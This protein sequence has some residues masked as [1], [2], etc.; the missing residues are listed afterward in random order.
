MRQLFHTGSTERDSLFTETI[1]PLWLI[2]FLVIIGES[3]GS[4]ALLL[5]LLTWFTAASLAV[6]IV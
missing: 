4:I 2:A 5:G 6:I 1:H 3:F